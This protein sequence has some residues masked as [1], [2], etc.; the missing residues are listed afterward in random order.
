MFIFLF[1][2]QLL[3]WLYIIQY[4]Y[5]LAGNG[6][7]RAIF[8]SGLFLKALAGCGLGLLYK[9]Y[10]QGGDTLGYFQDAVKLSSLFWEDVLLYFKILLDFEEINGLQ[11]ALQDRAYFFVK[12]ASLISLIS[13]QNYWLTAISFSLINFTCSWWFV[14][15]LNQHLPVSQTILLF[16]FV[17]YPSVFFWSAGLLKESIS[18]AMIYVLCGIFIE[19]YTQEQKSR[20]ALLPILIGIGC[21]WILWMLKYYYAAVLLPALLSLLVYQTLKAHTRFFSSR[22]QT[23]LIIIPTLLVIMLTIMQLHPNLKPAWILEVIVRNHNL[24]VAASEDGEYI[25][26]PSLNPSIRSFVYYFPKAVFSGLF[27]PLPGSGDAYL[28]LLA[29]LENLM[30]LGVSCIALFQGVVKR[31]KKSVSVLFL[32]TFSYVVVLAGLIALASP[33]FGSLIRYKVAYAPFW[34]CLCLWVINSVP[35]RNRTSQSIK[36]T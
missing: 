20:E 31:R 7:E 36:K 9:Y 18:L 15:K 28:R 29:G 2:L 21:A 14:K 19:A 5:K 24:S 35:R 13:L 26:Y 11:Y 22:R 25:R 32:A 8:F 17:F 16:S 23:L 12:I 30:V 6:Q 34:L 33:N 3:A 1:I 27:L 4:F 10:Y